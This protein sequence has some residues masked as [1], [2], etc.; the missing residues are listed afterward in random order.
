[1]K[2]KI[3]VC[4][5]SL[6]DV[7]IAEKAGADRVE[8]N[9]SMHLGGLTP[10]MGTIKLV[11]ER[12][13][14]STIVM[15][16]PRGAGFCYNDYQYDTMVADIEE[17]MKYNIAGVA[18]GCLTKN[19]EIDIEKNK[20]I[21]EIL[22]KND[23]QVVFHR[24]F[25]CVVDPYKSIEILIDLGVDRILTSGLASKAVEG[26]ELLKDLQKKYGQKIEILAGSGVNESNAK[27]IMDGTGISQYH[28]SCKTWEIDPTTIGN[29]VS[30][31]YANSPHEN[32]YNVV[33]YEKV[34]EL[35]NIVKE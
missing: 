16:R 31:A 27:Y 4:C 26:V 21:I 9:N 8:L 13:V 22:K 10:S 24:A 19:K 25:D 20:K 33:S 30:Y 1:M 6:E 23:K 14:I 34:K 35:I 17:M 18:F 15:A 11:S 29:D 12:C 32:E 2:K 28:S 3:E 7:I 5:D